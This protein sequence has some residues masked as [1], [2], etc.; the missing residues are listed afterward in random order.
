MKPKKEFS[1][2]VEL[3]LSSILHSLVKIVVFMA[4]SE[5]NFLGSTTGDDVLLSNEIFILLPVASPWSNLAN[6][7]ATWSWERAEAAP[8]CF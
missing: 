2:L 7:I 8:I 1:V 4:L 6:T 5:T 3:L